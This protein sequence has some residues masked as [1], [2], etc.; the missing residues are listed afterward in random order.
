M[1]L[2]SIE[3]AFPDIPKNKKTSG[4][5]VAAPKPGCSDSKPSKEERRAARRQ[6]KK[7][8]DGP[9][10]EYYKSVDDIPPPID[11]DRPAIKRMGEVPAFAAYDEAFNDL[12]GGKFE[13]FRMPVLPSANCLSSQPGYPSYFGKGLE[14]ADDDVGSSEAFTNMLS[15]SPTEEPAT[16][17]YE[18][19]GKG[20]AKAGGVKDLPAPSL[21]DAW[22]P[23]T[24]AK[25]RTAIVNNISGQESNAKSIAK[26]APKQQSE[27]SGSML[28]PAPNKP[29]TEMNGISTRINM[30]NQI[31]ELTRRF[32]DLEVK[33]QRNTQK[34]II[35][36]VG[37]GVFILVCMDIV[38]RLAK[39]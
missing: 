20:A 22:K 9:A 14:D 38:T 18:F 13:A 26:S 35:L 10:E 39:R 36:F 15:D 6:A 12:S 24:P 4:S 28:P 16:F 2:C 8:K 23:M 5:A 17:E 3:D 31:R 32:D 11:A 34:E 19:G 21:S 30:E 1:E 7:C 29:T 33:Q 37:T 25:A 27:V